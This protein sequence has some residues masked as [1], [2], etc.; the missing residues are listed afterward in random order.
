MAVAPGAR[1]VDARVHVF[2]SAAPAISGARYRPAYAARLEALRALWRTHGVTHGVIVQPSFFGTDNT[3]MLAAIA[4]DRDHLRGVAVVDP[5]FDD[6]ALAKLVDA[7]VVAIR[8]NLRGVKD[9]AP[10]GGEE[11]R[12]LYARA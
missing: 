11:W 10:Y 2:S 8:L 7:G 1:I 3:E 6:D 9:L 5:T 4:T 12:A